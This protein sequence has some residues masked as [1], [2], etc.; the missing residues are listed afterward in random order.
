MSTNIKSGGSAWLSALAGKPINITK[1]ASNAVN[2]A[3]SSIYNTLGIDKAKSMINTGIESYD[4]GKEN[5]LK[6]LAENKRKKANDTHQASLNLENEAIALELEAS[7][8]DDQVNK[9]SS[10]RLIRKNDPLESG[11]DVL[12]GNFSINNKND[13]NITKMIVNNNLGINNEPIDDIAGTINYNSITQWPLSDSLLNQVKINHNHTNMQEPILI[14]K[15]AACYTCREKSNRMAKKIAIAVLVIIVIII[16]ILMA[17]VIYND[18]HKDVN[19]NRQEINR[20][21]NN[22][23]G[24]KYLEENKSY[25]YNR[26]IADLERTALQM[27]SNPNM[28]QIPAP[29]LWQQ[30][31]YYNSPDYNQILASSE[32]ES[33]GPNYLGNFTM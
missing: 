23:S 13:D 16:I 18:N 5:D 6:I 19:L 27:A 17:V 33:Q 29:P 20:N 7:S 26:E 12:G 2:S 8:Y 11:G 24:N 14:P 9:L 25:P 4:I 31:I 15:D 1:S 22:F 21:I 28:F 30:P 32:Y 10:A 3:G